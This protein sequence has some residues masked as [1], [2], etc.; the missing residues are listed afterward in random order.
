MGPILVSETKI[1]SVV[2]VGGGDLRRSQPEGARRSSVDV[3]CFK[4]SG[5]RKHDSATDN[6]LRKNVRSGGG[7]GPNGR[8][9]SECG[10]VTVHGIVLVYA[11]E[12]VGWR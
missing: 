9:A 4:V 12:H 8:V 11:K 7:R 10:G 1:V 5:A 6:R 3:P 2:I